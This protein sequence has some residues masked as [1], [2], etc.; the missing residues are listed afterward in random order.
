MPRRKMVRNAPQGREFVF[1]TPE[2]R[3]VGRARNLMEFVSLIKQVPL[4]S[5][6][7]HANGGHFASWLEFIGEKNAAGKVRM[8]KGNTEQVRADIIESC[9]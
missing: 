1:K 8:I 4:T 3:E 2:G 6:L 9:T 5:V 7:Y